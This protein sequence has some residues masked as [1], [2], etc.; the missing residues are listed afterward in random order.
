[1]TNLD[2]WKLF[3][4]RKRWVYKEV[5]AKWGKSLMV[6]TY[7]RNKRCHI[8]ISENKLNFAFFKAHGSKM[9]VAY[10]RSRQTTYCLSYRND[11]LHIYSTF[12]GFF[13]NN[14]I[15]GPENLVESMRSLMNH[16][17][18]LKFKTPR[19]KFK[20]ITEFFLK[21]NGEKIGVDNKVKRALTQACYP[22][23]KNVPIPKVMLETGSI[24]R[25]RDLTFDMF[26]K[27]TMKHSSKIIKKEL[28]KGMSPGLFSIINI[29]RTRV[30]RG[31]IEKLI[32]MNEGKLILYNSK[33]SM[34]YFLNSY[35]NNKIFKIFKERT[36]KTYY[37]RDA[38]D[39][40]YENK[41]IIPPQDFK[42]I[43]DLHDKVTIQYKRLQT[44][45]YE[46]EPNK[47]LEGIDNLK[48]GNET[49][50][51]PKTKYELLEWGQK[52]NNCIASYHDSF[53]KKRTIILGIKDG[54]DIKYNIEIQSNKIQQFKED[55][56]RTA[57]KLTIEKY[58]KVFIEHKLIMEG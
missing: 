12:R 14:G 57:D 11:S 21:L 24:M 52:L 19:N 38:V 48:V 37:L 36:K 1:M 49:I 9:D 51:V 13:R 18:K 50:I 42:N 22:A 23:L 40:L 35:S 41:K 30:N 3:L 45:D 27:K 47:K 6:K 17:G 2:K 39:Q 46:F 4:K 10:V 33:K 31:E 5:D 32:Q 25:R 55:R 34:K 29:L 7:A 16:N 26:I 44:E 58:K 28:I 15:V 8:F 56:N 20:Y 53:N 43:K 54:N